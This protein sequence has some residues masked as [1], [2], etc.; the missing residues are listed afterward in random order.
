MDSFPSVHWFCII[1]MCYFLFHRI[2]LYFI[3]LFL[4]LRKPVHFLLRDRKRVDLDEKEGRNK[5]EGVEEKK[6]IEY[7]VRK[8]LILIKGKIKIKKRNSTIK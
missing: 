3:I 7:C 6:D 2:L 1:P 8:E 5:L 4:F